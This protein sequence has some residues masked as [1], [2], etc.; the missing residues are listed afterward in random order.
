MSKQLKN[1]FADL[2]TSA[3]R[4]RQ[5][6]VLERHRQQK[7]KQESQILLNPDEVSGGYDATRLLTTTLGGVVRPITQE[8][9]RQFRE[10]I[11][12]AGAKFKGGITAKQVIDLSLK[13]DRERS[14]EQIRTAIP[15]SEAGDV[16]HFVTNAGP[17]SIDTKHH[18]FVQFLGFSAAVASPKPPE[19]AVLEV[20]KGK[21]RLDCNCGRWRYFLRYVATIGNYNYKLG[22][23]NFPKLKN[24]S[25]A[26]VACKHLL[27]VNAMILQSPTLKNYIVQMIKRARTVEESRRRDHK[28]ID[29]KQLAEQLASERSRQHKVKTTE[30]KLAERKPKSKQAQVK[31]VAAAA[32]KAKARQAKAVD[33][34]RAATVANFQKLMALGA[35]TQ[36][37]YNAMV[38]SLG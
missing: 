13:I 24:P 10:N 35:I 18:V 37:Q 1:Q 15:V 9:L 12:R 26:G 28:V 5:H 6:E 38:K 30:E 25:L 34:T 32:A 22:E 27:R 4:A 31:V 29:Q 16:I 19:K 17:T 8:D 7:Q 23:H 21:V 33:K 2:I 36:D 11:R 20:L 3:T 14:N